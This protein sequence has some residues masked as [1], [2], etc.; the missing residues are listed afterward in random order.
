MQ[1]AVTELHKAGK[2]SGEIVRLLR[3]A[4][5]SRQFVHYTVQQYKETGG[6]SS[7]VCPLSSLGQHLRGQHLCHLH[8][9][10]ASTSQ[11]HPAARRPL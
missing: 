1:S 8:L 10:S 2:S 6:S 11:R 5:I 4:K 3:T 7:E 9:T